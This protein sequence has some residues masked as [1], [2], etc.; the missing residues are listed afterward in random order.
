MVIPL[1][2]ARIDWMYQIGFRML[3]LQDDEKVPDTDER[4]LIPYQCLLMEINSILRTE[5][6]AHS[7]RNIPV[8]EVMGYIHEHLTEKISLQD[9][10]NHVHIGKTKLC[11]DFQ[12]FAS[13]SVHQYII[14]E[15]LLL[16]QQYLKME[17]S[18]DEVAKLC[19]LGNGAHFTHTFRKYFSISPMQYRHLQKTKTVADTE[20]P[21]VI[22]S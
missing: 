10:A 13:M 14:R 4:F 3:R 2:K 11:T 20:A 12:K 16:A 6:T 5:T 9:I 18:I 7:N 1:S 15:R 21:A 22:G 19:C 8:M 17:Y